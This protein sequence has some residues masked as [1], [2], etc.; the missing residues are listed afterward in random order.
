MRKT[1][2]KDLVQYVER[3]LAAWNLVHVLVL[4]GMEGGVPTWGGGGY[5]LVY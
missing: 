1:A 2:L 4:R 3:D 5:A